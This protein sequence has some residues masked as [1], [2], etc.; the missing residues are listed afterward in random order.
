M[1]HGQSMERGTSKSS[2]VGVWLMVV[3]SQETSLAVVKPRW[4]VVGYKIGRV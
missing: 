1:D 3:R 4:E 2:W